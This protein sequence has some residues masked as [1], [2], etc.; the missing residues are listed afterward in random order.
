METSSNQKTYA[1]FSNSV[2]RKLV[3]GLEQNG[4]K[5]FSFEPIKAEIINAESNSKIIINAL[6]EIEWIIFPDVFTVEYFLEILEEIRVDLFELDAA[7]VLAFGEAVADRLRFVQLH[8]DI[9][10][11]STQTETV[12]SALTDYLGREN[13]SELKFLFPKEVTFDS[14]LT[15]KLIASG[16]NVTEVIIYQIK[17][18]EKN[19]RS[20]LK[21]LIKGGAI[22]EFVITSAEDIVSLKHYLSTENLSEV[23]SDIRISGVD[24]NSMQILREN[25]LRPNFFH[26]K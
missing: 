4:A 2:Y 22:D 6:S 15:D 25:N 1:L 3:A 21:A 26:I 8:A 11:H 16:A 10:P 17:I 5:V 24:E 12:F 19:K 9:I 13:F 18:A 23:L 14:K 7:R 20:N